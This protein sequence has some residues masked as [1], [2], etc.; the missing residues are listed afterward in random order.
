MAQLPILDELRVLADCEEP[1]DMFDHFYEH[2]HEFAAI[3]F[4]MELVQSRRHVERVVELPD[5]QICT[6]MMAWMQ[7]LM[8]QFPDRAAVHEKAK[9]GRVKLTIPRLTKLPG[10]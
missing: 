9:N 7:S 5:R 1:E 4:M 2:G 6:A 8:D 10:Q 3:H